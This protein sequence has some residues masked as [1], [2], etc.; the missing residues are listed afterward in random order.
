[1]LFYNTHHISHG[2]RHI[3]REEEVPC[4]QG[5]NPRNHIREV[6]QIR[7]W[8]TCLIVR[9]VY[10]YQVQRLV[11]SRRK[12]V[13]CLLQYFRF[14]EQTCLTPC[15]PSEYYT[16][17]ELD[18]A[19]RK[20]LHNLATT[21]EV[22]TRPPDVPLASWCP[23]D[24]SCTLACGAQTPS[25]QFVMELTKISIWEGK[26]LV[27]L[28]TQVWACGRPQV[29]PFPSHCFSGGSN[30]DHGLGWC[31][32]RVWESGRNRKGRGDENQ[33]ADSLM[34]MYTY[35][36]THICARIHLPTTVTPT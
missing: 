5:T 11:W 19:E 10:W 20:C 31:A 26:R 2:E 27:V 35:I 28:K 29:W 24:I 36:H 32:D 14:L 33:N 12:G 8:L 21:V 15:E 7:D 23:T 18:H 25:T 17:L 22:R 6:H 1:M 3:G 34:Y 9:T 4:E 13:Q 16:Q 30:L